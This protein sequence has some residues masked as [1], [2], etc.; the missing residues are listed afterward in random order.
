MTP[1]CACCGE[2]AYFATVLPCI[3]ETVYYCKGCIYEAQ[4]TYGDELE[5]I[6]EKYSAKQAAEDLERLLEK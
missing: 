2:E 5:I 4:K 1:K 6:G 3:W